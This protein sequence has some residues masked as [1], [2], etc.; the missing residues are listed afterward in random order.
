MEIQFKSIWVAAKIEEA[1]LSN[2]SIIGCDKRA[3]N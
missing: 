3:A 1:N 2:F